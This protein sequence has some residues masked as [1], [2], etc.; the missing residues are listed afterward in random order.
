MGGLPAL[1][2]W[3]AALTDAGLGY[4]TEGDS[5]AGLAIRMAGKLR[6]LI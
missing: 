3:M 4:R 2:V 1:V 5:D 6:K